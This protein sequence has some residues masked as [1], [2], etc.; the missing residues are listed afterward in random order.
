MDEKEQRV[1]MLSL[2]LAQISRKG[3]IEG[4]SVI[5]IQFE[6]AIRVQ[7][8]SDN[9][10]CHRFHF[11]SIPGRHQQMHAGGAILP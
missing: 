11:C 1:V 9:H 7:Q 10:E 5:K 6:R 4:Q 2:A 3:N 8:S